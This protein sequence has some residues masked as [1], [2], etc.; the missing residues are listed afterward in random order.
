MKEQLKQQPDNYTQ[1]FHLENH[2]HLTE[3]DDKILLGS[4][5]IYDVT[6]GI[7]SKHTRTSYQENFNRFLNKI[8]I[9][10]KQVLLDCSHYPFLQNKQR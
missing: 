9:H 7:Q 4:S 5:K 2:C 8:K 3:I 6:A 10:D 1:Q